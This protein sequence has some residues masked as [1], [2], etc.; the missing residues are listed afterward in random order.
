[1]KTFFCFALVLCLTLSATPAQ[2]VTPAC[3]DD[4]DNDGDGQVDFPKDPGCDSRDDTN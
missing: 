2:V 4:L 3:R 1:M